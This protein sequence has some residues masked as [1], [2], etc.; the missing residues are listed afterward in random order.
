M[1]LQYL[2]VTM[3]LIALVC[4]TACTEEETSGPAWE[5]RSPARPGQ[6]M[7]AI[8]D[9]TGTGIP[10]GL[11]DTITFKVGLAPNA[12]SVRMENVSIVYADAVRSETLTPVAGIRGNPPQGSWG[13]VEVKDEEGTPNT[14]L[15]YDEQFVIRLNPKA[16]LVPRQLIMI[17]VQP[18][19]GPPLTLRRVAPATVVGGD[20][21]L[22]AL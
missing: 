5:A 6:L 2:L 4:A 14:R 1:K 13:V 12:T 8:G 15:E 11:I 21:V 17:V 22:P 16:P 7:V 10:G 3:I 18:P 19:S 20:A 9:V